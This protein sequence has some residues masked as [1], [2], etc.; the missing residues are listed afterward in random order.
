MIYVKFGTLIVIFLLIFIASIPNDVKQDLMF[1]I[2]EI[3][4]KESESL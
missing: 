4:Q 1:R 2:K 3:V